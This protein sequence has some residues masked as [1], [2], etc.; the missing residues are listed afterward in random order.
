MSNSQKA[1]SVGGSRFSIP[2]SHGSH[3]ASVPL[4][5]SGGSQISIARSNDKKVVMPQTPIFK[6][7]TPPPRQPGWRERLMKKVECSRAKSLSRKSCSLFKL[8]GRKRAAPERD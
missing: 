8:C 6:D 1:P 3:P 5:A 2:S 4:V 7:I